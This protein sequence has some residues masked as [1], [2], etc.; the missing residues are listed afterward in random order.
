MREQNAFAHR[1]CT[2]REKDYL[3]SLWIDLSIF[4]LGIALFAESVTFLYPVVDVNEPVIT[5]RPGVFRL[6]A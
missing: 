3:C 2:G 5:L 6:L 1:S 4:E